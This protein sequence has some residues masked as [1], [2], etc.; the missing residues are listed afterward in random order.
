MWASSR[1]YSALD[2]AIARIFRQAKQ[3]NEIVRTVRGVL[4]TLLLVAFPIIVVFAGTV[5]QALL[6]LIPDANTRTGIANL[7]VRL[8]AAG[9]HVRCCSWSRP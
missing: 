6:D 5:V 9:R 7:V 4:L 8:A 3:R 2:Y 1:F